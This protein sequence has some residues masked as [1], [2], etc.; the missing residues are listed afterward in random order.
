MEPEAVREKIL[1]YLK[2]E[3]PDDEI[4]SFE[5]TLARWPNGQKELEETRQLLDALAATSE[6]HVARGVNRI[7]EEAIERGAREIH[8]V[9]ERH[10]VIVYLRVGER[11]EEA[12]RYD[13]ALHSATIDRWKHLAGCSLAQRELP[14]EGHVALRH[15]GEEYDLAVTF[16]PTLAGERVTVRVSHRPE[17]SVALAALGFST[18]QVERLRE[19]LAQPAGLLLVAGPVGSGHS[20]VLHA[21][22]NQARAEK[23]PAVILSVEEAIDRVLEGV[24]QV[25]VDPARGMTF[26]TA[27]RAVLRSS[28]DLVL[29]GDLPDG[30]SAHVA[31]RGAAEGRQML[32][33]LVARGAADAVC[34][35]SE[36]SGDA[37]LVAQTV[38]GVVGLRRLRRVCDAC[39]TDYHPAPE[40]LRIAALSGSEDGPF[41]RGEGCDACHHTGYQGEVNLVEI[42][43]LSETLRPLITS[44]PSEEALQAA[45]TWGSVPTLWDDARDKIRRGVTTVEEARRAL[46]GEPP[47]QLGMGRN[48]LVP[49]E[50]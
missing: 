5:A 35:L 37:T 26:V 15:A 16:L 12:R 36:L 4:E 39:A 47:P 13:R 7:L 29:C 25:A 20:G 17:P 46:L 34:R 30:D 49:T 44:R 42:L 32:A 2:G 10:V 18:T 22:L 24:C 14:Q 8:L 27:L 21:L 45:M 9:P 1:V 38:I 11:L 40:L 41:R 28:P 48:N 31:L 3:M 50:V 33:G 6:E 23:S 19:L 43:S